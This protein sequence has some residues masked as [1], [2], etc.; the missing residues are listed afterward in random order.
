MI[1]ANPDQLFHNQSPWRYRRYREINNFDI[2]HFGGSHRV[3]VPEL[4]KSSCAVK[5]IWRSWEEDT[6]PSFAGGV[7]VPGP[8]FNI[9][10]AGFRVQGSGFR[11]QGAYTLQGSGFRVQGSGSRVHTP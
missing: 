2:N 11:V 1:A 5:W 10:G 7:R 8:R 9:Q 3:L 4:G 6:P